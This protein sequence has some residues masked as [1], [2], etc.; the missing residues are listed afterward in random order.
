[1]N[2]A[3]HTNGAGS[4]VKGYHNYGIQRLSRFSEYYLVFKE[5]LAIRV[6]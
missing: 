1:M 5:N 4:V 2:K 3:G 6:C